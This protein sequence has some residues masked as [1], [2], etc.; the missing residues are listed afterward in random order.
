MTDQPFTRDEAP[1]RGVL[2]L[3]EAE[4]E[5][6]P[7]PG[8]LRLVQELMEAVVTE[9]GEEDLRVAE[10]IRRR[11]EAGESQATLA[12]DYGFVQGHVSA[13]L[14]GRRLT[15]RL[16]A[17]PG[18]PPVEGLI[19][20]VAAQKWLA[21][22]GLIGE[23]E[24]I[25]AEGLE[26]LLELRLLLREMAEANN[27][28]PLDSSVLESLDRIAAD[29][30]LEFRFATGDAPE[31][32][33]RASGA[34]AAIGRLLAIVFEAMRD[35]TWPRMKICAAHDCP[36]TFYDSSRNRTGTWCVMAICGNRTKV[37]SYQERR[38]AARA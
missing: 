38:R 1:P 22:R 23:S 17:S 8:T 18:E 11:F 14:R 28:V 30:P 3:A 25:T 19:S 12:A 20:P 13:I 37:R 36:G 16:D 21:E 33:P 35:G 26:R 4:R 29:A 24:A 6:T 15:R 10:E 9:P 31:L 7:A 32:A 27:G 34:N 5:R 2:R